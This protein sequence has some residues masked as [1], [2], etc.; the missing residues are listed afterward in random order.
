MEIAR[1]Y[2]AS[3]FTINAE[4]ASVIAP[5]LPEWD[6]DCHDEMIRDF[7]A[8]SGCRACPLDYC[9]D[10]GRSSYPFP[11]WGDRPVLFSV[12]GQTNL[13]FL[14]FWSFARLL[15]VCVCQRT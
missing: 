2:N 5:F 12:M 8:G 6:Q 15:A 3:E 11:T 13:L 7:E 4:S 14:L 10:H 9:A 1:L